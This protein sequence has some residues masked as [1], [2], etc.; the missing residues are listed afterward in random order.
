[1]PFHTHKQVFRPFYIVIRKKMSIVKGM[2][3]KKMRKLSCK[4]V[5]MYWIFF[6][7]SSL[8]FLC[9]CSN[10]DEVRTGVSTAIELKNPEGLIEKNE[11]QQKVV[12]S[13]NKEGEQY[14]ISNYSFETDT[15]SIFSP[16]TES[17]EIGSKLQL[18]KNVTDDEIIQKISGFTN[19]SD[20][21]SVSF[22]QEISAVP[23]Y[24][25]CFNNG[26]MI[27]MLNDKA[28]GFVMNYKYDSVNEIYTYSQYIGPYYMPEELL[29]LII[30]NTNE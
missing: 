6:I 26:T 21:K 28:Y 7:C 10:V 20:W 29:E 1:M 3:N 12:D 11:S 9:A 15:V 18:L 22:E 27:S 25:I 4:M 17:L 13:E 2:V 5:F 19:I 14:M 30:E 24:Y 8:G 23:E 16:N